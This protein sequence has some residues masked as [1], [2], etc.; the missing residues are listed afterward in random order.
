M[1]MA[2]LQ[3]YQADSQKIHAAVDAMLAPIREYD[4]AHG[5][6][7]EETFR[8]LLRND[9]D[10]KVVAEQLFLH[11]NTV[12]QRKQKI[13]SLYQ[14]DPFLLPSKKQ[15]EFAFILEELYPL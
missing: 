15:F 12:L 4:Q 14:Q 10:Y 1:Y 13:T 3:S 2:L 11:K 5:S 9:M 6:A 7:L 8:C